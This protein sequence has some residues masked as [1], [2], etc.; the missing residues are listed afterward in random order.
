MM[1]Q[2]SHR[3]DAL[4]WQI[5]ALLKENGRVTNRDIARQIGV[6]R[7]TVGARIQRMTDAGALRIVA[8]VDFDA[9]G[10]A[11]LLALA[12]RVAGRA[13]EDV[14]RDLAEL[15]DVFAVHLVTGA[16]QVEALIALQAF[17]DLSARVMPRLGE[18]AGIAQVD[19]CIATEI[20]SYNFDVG[21]TR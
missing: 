8:A 20:V 21:I 4:D 13:A 15:P 1:Q 5:V 19:V 3:F 17:E 12:I 2:P 11:V 6:P 10:H 7:A 18:I 9:Y 14:G 16:H